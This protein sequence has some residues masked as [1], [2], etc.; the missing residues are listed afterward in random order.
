MEPM[1]MFRHSKLNF[2]PIGIGLAALAVLTFTSGCSNASPEPGSAQETSAAA[3][4]L[5]AEPTASPNEIE[6]DA[7]REFR[8]ALIKSQEG[9][10]E[11]GLTELWFDSDG[12][13]VQVVVQDPKT[14]T[15][16]SYDIDADSVFEMDETSMMPA[17]TIAELDGLMAGGEDQG[18]ITSEAS[19]RFTVTNI[20][21]QSTYITVY[22]LDKEGRIEKSVISS[23]DEPLGEITYTYGVTKE[24]KSALD[25][26][27][28][29]N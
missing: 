6:P 23:D 13:M 15:F 25:A 14:N 17:R 12:V 5:E 7:E 16:A 21:D 10:A 26:L 9:A 19:G 20:I 3:P 29:S 4:T 11:S 2:R 24:G 18:S 27:A 28:A 8:A 22:T 1:N